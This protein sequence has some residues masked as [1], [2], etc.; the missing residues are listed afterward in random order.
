MYLFPFDRHSLVDPLFQSCLY[1]SM[2][3]MLV[4]VQI[5]RLTE[6][7]EIGKADVPVCT[8]S[9]FVTIARVAL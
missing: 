4:L 1:G 3:A 2:L 5:L 6:L 7:L 8:K 9:A